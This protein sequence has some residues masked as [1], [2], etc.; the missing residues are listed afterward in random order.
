M[1]G[2]TEYVEAE[3]RGA[4]HVLDPREIRFNPVVFEGAMPVVV[5]WVANNLGPER[6]AIAL[7]L[8][9]AI[10]VFVRNRESGVVR[11]LSVLGFAIVAL[12]AVIGI[13]FESDKAFAAQN[14]ASDFAIAAISLLSIVIGRPLM[15]AVTRE[16]IPA[17][18]PLL[19]TADKVFVTLTAVNVVSNLGQAAMRLWL[20]DVLDTNDYVI[21][22]RVFGIPFTVAYIGIAYVLIGRRLEELRPAPVG[23]AP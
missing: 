9:A 11:A 10:V 21:L 13:V 17:L 7:S 8:V 18:A 4:R 2:V 3:G 14:I 20:I 22:S 15:G 1:A 5:F 12:S 16:L 6:V 23:V 19:A